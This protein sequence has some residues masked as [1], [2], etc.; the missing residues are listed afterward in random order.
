MSTDSRPSTEQLL[1]INAVFVTLD[2][3]MRY[4]VTEWGEWRPAIDTWTAMDDQR[5]EAIVAKGL[6]AY[7]G[8]PIKH[9][10]V[11]SAEDPEY[12]GL[13]YRDLVRGFVVYGRAFTTPQAA[14][15]SVLE[16]LGYHGK[17]GGWVYRTDRGQERAVTQGWWQAAG[18][19]GHFVSQ[20]VGE[21][22]RWRAAI[23]TS[24][25]VAVKEGSAS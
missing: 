3:G 17:T 9:Y 4:R 22:G 7:K 23:T 8:V 25:Q 12:S 19:T 1:D 18:L 14:A 10:E 16:P 2:N 13:E 11:R 6:V 24:L 15:R 20:L 21:R 5:R